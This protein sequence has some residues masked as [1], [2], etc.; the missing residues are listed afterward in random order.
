MLWI[1]KMRCGSRSTAAAAAAQMRRYVD[2]G[3]TVIAE[4]RMNVSPAG[5][6]AFANVWLGKF[7]GS[8]APLFNQN[9]LLTLLETAAKPLATRAYKVVDPYTMEATKETGDTVNA[10]VTVMVSRDGKTITETVKD[11]NAQGH[12]AAQNVV[13]YDRQ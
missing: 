11:F 8:N 3:N 2:R 13:V 10:T 4:L 7:D 9:D 12:Q 1:A 6:V 5:A